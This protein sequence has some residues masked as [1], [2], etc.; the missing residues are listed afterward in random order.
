LKFLVKIK[1]WDLHLLIIIIKMEYLLKTRNF[2]LEKNLRLKCQTLTTYIL[3][4]KLDY[5]LDQNL[6]YKLDQKYG[7]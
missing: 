7:L 3:D 4:Q 5:I 6:D 1:N 2:I